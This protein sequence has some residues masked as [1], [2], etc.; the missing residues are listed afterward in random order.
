MYKVVDYVVEKNK[1]I[2]IT[3]KL[4]NIIFKSYIELRKIGKTGT[5]TLN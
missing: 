3:T 4:Q 2:K 5:N 1:T